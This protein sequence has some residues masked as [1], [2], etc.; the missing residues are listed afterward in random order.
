MLQMKVFIGVKI[1]GTVAKIHN[2]TKPEH[3][4]SASLVPSLAEFHELQA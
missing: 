4:A 1:H 3:T 2:S